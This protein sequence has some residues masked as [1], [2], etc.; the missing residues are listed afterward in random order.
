MVGQHRHPHLARW[1][2][3]QQCLGFISP[4]LGRPRLAKRLRHGAGR[5][6]WRGAVG[7]RQLHDRVDVRRWLHP[8]FLLQ[9]QPHRRFEPEQHGGGGRAESRLH[10][11]AP[12]A[13]CRHDRRR[14]NRPGRHH[15]EGR[16]LDRRQHHLA[17]GPQ[18]RA[19]HRLQEQHG[20]LRFRR[21]ASAG[22]EHRAVP[23]PLSPEQGRGGL[24]QGQRDENR[25]RA[26][27]SVGRTRAAAQGAS[28][29]QSRQSRCQRGGRVL[30]HGN[31]CRLAHPG[32]ALWQ[33][34]VLPVPPRP[35]QRRSRRRRVDDR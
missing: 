3:G 29:H 13:R 33:R 18:F 1:R 35:G 4:Q 23:H 30:L 28:R 27:S 25:D 16:R 32:G 12:G 8:A 20:D 31:E 14:G 22:G 2:A 10:R 5:H 6:L 17:P 24:P 19:D 34:V 11:R 21:R 7:Y 15:P 26:G 9:R